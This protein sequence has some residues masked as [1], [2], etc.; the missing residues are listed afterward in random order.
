MLESS[1]PI[2]TYED[3]WKFKPRRLMDSTSI[4]DIRK[5]VADAT[6]AGLRV[7]SVGFGSS[8]CTRRPSAMPQRGRKP[9]L[10]TINFPVR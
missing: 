1:P 9:R 6:S 8:G 7:R 4:D 10:A 5:E 2:T 3:I